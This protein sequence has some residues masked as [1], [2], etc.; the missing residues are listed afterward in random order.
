MFTRDYKAFT[1]EDLRSISLDQDD[2][3][4]CLLTLNIDGK[5]MLVIGHPIILKKKDGPGGYVFKLD[6]TD[7]KGI[8][9]FCSFMR[10]L[11]YVISK[12]I[13]LISKQLY[14]KSLTRK[15]IK[16]MTI[17]IV[18]S[19][20]TVDPKTGKLI[21]NNHT[22]S[23]K[24]TN[25]KRNKHREMATKIIETESDGNTKTEKIIPGVT[26]NSFI[27][28]YPPGTKFIPIYLIDSVILKRRSITIDVGLY[29]LKAVDIVTKKKKKI[30]TYSDSEE[31]ESDQE[32]Y[33]IDEETVYEKSIPKE[34]KVEE[35]TMEQEEEGES[36]DSYID[37]GESDD[38]DDEESA[39]EDTDEE[40]YDGSEF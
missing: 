30:F 37:E 38:S 32:S 11:K 28:K 24:M 8:S 25:I 6:D 17:P 33:L 14:R 20:C 3:D 4:E 9:Y 35:K 23:I 10:H 19:V 2:T 16:D 7:K 39:N 34:S 27:K 12:K 21:I 40:G 15:T 31:D 1:E 18:K 36:D 5:D 26:V 22:I 13:A 29:E